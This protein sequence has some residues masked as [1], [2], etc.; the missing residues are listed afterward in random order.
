MNDIAYRR[1]QLKTLQEDVVNLEDISGAISITDLTYTDFKSDLSTA[2]KKY[3]E[4]LEKAPKGM[5]AVASN[6]ELKEADSG[7]IFCLKEVT[8][9][10]TLRITWLPTSSS[11]SKITEKQNTITRSRRRYWMSLEKYHWAKTSH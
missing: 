2:L 6:E 4:E 11:I 5:Y 8:G 1:N 10:E 3:K 9:S 7:V